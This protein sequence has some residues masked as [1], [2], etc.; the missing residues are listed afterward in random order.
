M[1]YFL[2]YLLILLTRLLNIDKAQIY[3]W[4]LRIFTPFQANPSTAV[5]HILFLLYVV[6]APWQGYMHLKS[7][8]RYKKRPTEVGRW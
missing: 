8:L 2:L 4:N 3:V 6:M 5:W 1:Y 7:S